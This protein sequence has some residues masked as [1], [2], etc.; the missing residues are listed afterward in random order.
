[1][2]QPSLRDGLKRFGKKAAQ[3]AFKEVQQLHDMKTFFLRNTNSLM[4]EER[5]KVLLLLLLK[6]KDNV[7]IKE[8]TCVKGAPQRGYIH[9]DNAVSPT[10]ATD[11]VFITGAFDAHEY[12]DVAFCN[13]PGAF[14][15]TLM[16]KHVIMVL[17]GEL[18]KLMCMVDP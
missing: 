15:H 10:A 4:R 16:G 11:S 6:E 9:K 1:M 18:C 2:I 13:L 7:D 12:H 8:C 14:L 5:K 3:G 17:H